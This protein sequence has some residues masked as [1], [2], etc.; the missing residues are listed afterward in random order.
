LLTVRTRQ[1]VLEP[2]QCEDHPVLGDSVKRVLAT[3]VGM[4]LGLGVTWLCLF[5]LSPADLRQAGS[6][7]ACSDAE[8]CDGRWWVGMANLGVLLFP[9]I[10]CGA[11]GYFAV[12]RAWAS[13]KVVLVFGAL[14]AGT[15][16]VATGI[17]GRLGAGY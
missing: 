10:A 14:I 1:L 9:A 3:L 7:S 13:R 4:G 5:V 8:H 2:G 6:G 15:A 16:L 17:Y 11:A 12:A